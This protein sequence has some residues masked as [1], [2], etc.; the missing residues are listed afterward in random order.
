MNDN[1]GCWSRGAAKG[2]GTDEGLGAPEGLGATEGCGVAVR[3]LLFSSKGRE[4]GASCRLLRLW[5]PVEAATR[6]SVGC[7]GILEGPT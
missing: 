7:V 6:A 5:R 2:L 1:L 3:S 4:G